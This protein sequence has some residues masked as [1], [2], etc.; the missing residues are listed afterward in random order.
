MKLRYKIATGILMF[1]GIA[2]A[3]LALVLG[4]TSD[5]EP[6]PAVAS[7]AVLMKAIVYRCYGSPDILELADVEKPEPADDEV[8]VKVHA[9]AVN[10]YD[11]H[12]MRGSPYFMRLG[13]GI[14]APTETRLGADFAGIVEAVGSNVTRYKPGDPVFGGATGAFGDYVTVREAGGMVSIPSG[15]TF[16]Q[17]AAVPIAGLTALQALRDH[18]QLKPGQKVLINGASGGVGTFA[19]QLARH[20]G[21]EVTGVCST[22]NADMVRSIGADHV[23]DYKQE[24]YTE[25]DERYD[26]IVDMVGNHSLLA[27]RKVLVPDGRMVLVGGAKGNWIGPLIGP[28]KAFLLSPFVGQEMGMMIAQFRRDDLRLIGELIQAGELTPVID[29]IYPLDEVAEAIR[30]SES[31]RARGKIIIA[32]K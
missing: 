32:V 28:I 27:N 14:G 6:A 31:G 24:D 5:C 25:G 4:H 15:V 29:Q 22:R 13:T 1:L 23:I 10:P 17:A 18:G 3:S 26:L 8:L 9:A 21:A 2:T 19:V 12:F 7:D 30:Y 20:F 11:W 16:E